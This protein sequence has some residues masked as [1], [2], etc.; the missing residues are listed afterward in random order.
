M[1]SGSTGVRR[2]LHR[3]RI[4]VVMSQGVPGMLA[5][6]WQTYANLDDARLGA[7]R[8][9]RDPRVLAVAIVEDGNPLTFVEWM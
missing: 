5:E 9:R 4:L 6:A 1:D 3:L 8:A 2:A 7:R